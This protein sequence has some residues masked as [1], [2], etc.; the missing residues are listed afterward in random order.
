MNKYDQINIGDSQTIKHTITQDDIDKFVEV[1]GDNNKLHVDAEFASKTSF[2]KPVA[3][4]MLGASFISAIIGTK[5]P[6]DGAL[7]YSQS[8]EFLLPIRVGDS[9]T[10]IAT[11]LKKTNRQ[12][13]IDIQ[14]DIFNQYKQKVTS[15]IAKVKILENELIDEVTNEYE[16]VA[17]VVGAS[18]GIGSETARVLAQNGYNLILHYN[19]N[20]EKT[21]ALKKEIEGYSDKKT[22]IVKADISN[23]DEIRNII[24]DIQRYFKTITAFVNASTTNFGNIK[25]DAM[26]W[27]DIESQININVKSSFW[28]M[29]YLV[30]LMESNGYGKVV[31]ISSQAVE[32]VNSEW[33]HYIVAKSSLGG[34]AKALAHELAPKGIRVNIVSAGMTD[35]ELICNIP[36]KAKLLTSTR[37]PLKRLGLPID[38][39][40]AIAYLVSEKSDFL[41][42][43]T[44]RVNGGQV[45]I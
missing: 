40:N 34:F 8:L 11:V 13:S 42:G 14:T 24:F 45:M 26:K 7:W 37:T 23:E 18:G 32:Q 35:T 21:V 39:A 5:M 27:D 22:I 28:F 29:Q 17:L 30:P 43:E 25:F 20:K 36:E 12:H 31:F 38:I 16:K 10:I 9:L 33:L 6:G 4:G 15:G 19:K 3:H 41:T 2:K 1:S 44:I